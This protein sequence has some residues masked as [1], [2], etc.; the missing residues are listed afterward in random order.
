V[1]P[2]AGCLVDAEWFQRIARLAFHPALS[3]R[4]QDPPCFL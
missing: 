2:S 1:R 4:R 3:E